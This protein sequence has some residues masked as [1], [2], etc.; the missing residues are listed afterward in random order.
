MPHPSH[1]SLVIVAYI[2]MASKSSD[3]D[4]MEEEG[5]VK[6]IKLEL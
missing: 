4:N 3:E 5:A 2:K 6:R 1:S